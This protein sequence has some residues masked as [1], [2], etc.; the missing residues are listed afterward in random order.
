MD[1]PYRRPGNL[2]MYSALF[3]CSAIS[4]FSVPA[5]TLRCAARSY[6]QGLRKQPRSG[7]EG[8]LDGGERGATISKPGV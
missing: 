7:A 1:R 5:A 4:R 8:V 6:R 2:N 3:L